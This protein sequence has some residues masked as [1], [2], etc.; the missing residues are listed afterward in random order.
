MKQHFTKLFM[1]LAVVGL[2]SFSALAQLSGTYTIGS[3]TGANYTSITAAATALNSGGI[4]G[5][6]VFEIEDGTYTGEVDISSSIST[7]STNTVTFRGKSLDST[8]VTVSATSGNVF[9]VDADYVIIEHVTIQATTRQTEGVELSGDNNLVQNC[10]FIGNTTGYQWNNNMIYNTGS[11]NTVQNSNFNGSG[12]YAIYDYR[13]ENSIY[14]GLVMKHFYYNGFYL[15]ETEGYEITNCLIDSGGTTFSD[16]IYSYRAENGYINANQ[17]YNQGYGIYP[18]QEQ[19]NGGDSTVIT[20][21][22][23]RNISRNALYVFGGSHMRIYHNVF[24]GDWDGAY[25]YGYQYSWGGYPNVDC[26]AM[27]NIFM[28][29]GSSYYPFEFRFFTNL[30][31]SYEDTMRVL[32][33]NDYYTVGATGT[34]VLYNTVMAYDAIKTNYKSQGHNAVNVDPDFAGDYDYETFV[35]GLNNKG[36]DVDVDKDINGNDRP[37][38]SDTRVDIGANDFYLP[39]YDL[40]IVELTSPMQVTLSANTI[41]ANFKS[42]GSDTIKNFDAIVEYSVDSGTSWVRDTFEITSMAPGA[43]QTFTFTQTWTPSRSGNFSIYVRIATSV[44]NDPDALDQIEVDVCTPLAAGKYII[45]ASANADYATLRDA[46]ALLSRCGVGGAVEFEIENGTYSGAL[47]FSDVLGVSASN[48]VTFKGSD[49]DSVIIENG[50]NVITL[51]GASYMTFMDLTI[52]NTTTAQFTVW[53]TNKSDY[54]TFENCLITMPRSTSSSAVVV[55]MSNSSTSVFGYADNGNRNTFDNCDLRG[56]YYSFVLAGNN[57]LPSAT[58]GNSIIDCTADDVEYS[59]IRAYYQDSLTV[60]GTRFE[61]PSRI[62]GQGC[63]IF[64]MA[65]LEWNSN[66]VEGGYNYLYY[67]DGPNGSPLATIGRGSRVVNSVFIANYASTYNYGRNYL[68]YNAGARFSHNVFEAKN[69]YYNAVYMFSNQDIYFTN[70]VIVYEE[71]SRTFRPGAV[72]FQSSTFREFDY[73][74]Y[75]T[76]DNVANNGGTVIANLAALVDQPATGLNRNNYSEDP[77]FDATYHY[78]SASPQLYGT[79]SDVETDMDGDQRCLMAPTVGP[80]EIPTVQL[81]PRAN[82]VS[83]DTLWLG[84]PAALLNANQPSRTVMASWYLNGQ[85]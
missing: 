26:H 80:D 83:D 46:A 81:P 12:Y 33:H 39:P 19:Y 70:N 52:R 6:V 85:F 45:G 44:A 69:A 48:T 55:A 25:F 65:N 60:T 4:S 79:R 49:R 35:V 13:G 77:E 11:D 14:D 68:Y 17:I 29:T 41:A 20:N 71:S 84:S 56:G 62:W 34:N 43:V 67:L 47:N 78:T 1:V 9:D 16:G 36:K 42:S 50:G 32:D 64:Q 7:S 53:L 22:V 40:D 76:T 75:F 66:F 73:N 72:Y 21:N 23:C 15:R 10:R 27:N 38:S 63:Y 59:G 31:G 3:S 2:S 54:N 5:A 82:F 30:T 57:Q 61:A 74:N 8:K 37:N 51:N 28:T 18:N 24:E 58:I